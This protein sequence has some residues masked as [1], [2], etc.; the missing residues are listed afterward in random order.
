MYFKEIE[1]TTPKTILAIPDHYDANPIMVGDTGVT[2]DADG[3]KIVPAGTILGGG[4]IAD[5][6][7]A[8]QKSVDGQSEP[9]VTAVA[10]EGVLMNDVDVTGGPQIGALIIHGFIDATKLPE[11]HTATMVTALKQITF[12]GTKDDD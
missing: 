3:R 9:L 7:K 4:V 6:S 11:A 8:A 1:L 10:A 5:R 12:I 2:A